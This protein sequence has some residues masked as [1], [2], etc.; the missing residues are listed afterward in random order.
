MCFYVNFEI[1]D[2]WLTFS[3][4]GTCN[5]LIP[6]FSQLLPPIEFVFLEYVCALYAMFCSELARPGPKKWSG[7]ARPGPAR[8]KVSRNTPL[9]W[10]VFV[11]WLIN[12]QM[13]GLCKNNKILSSDV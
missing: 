12:W 3:I 1:P 6:G 2:F 13:P 11:I 8:H 4:S 7:P 9:E 5:R 10:T